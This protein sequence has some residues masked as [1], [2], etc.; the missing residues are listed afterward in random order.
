MNG[1]FAFITGCIF[2]IFGGLCGIY[3]IVTRKGNNGSSS[4]KS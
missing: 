3:E 4:K 1:L 2:L